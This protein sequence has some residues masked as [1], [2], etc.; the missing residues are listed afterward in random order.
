MIV[1]Q[2]IVRNRTQSTVSFVD[3]VHLL[4]AGLQQ[5]QTAQHSDELPES[6]N[7]SSYQ[8]RR[9]PIDPDKNGPLQNASNRYMYVDSLKWQTMRRTTPGVMWIVSVNVGNSSAFN[10]S[11]YRIDRCIHRRFIKRSPQE[12]GCREFRC[13]VGIQGSSWWRQHG[14]KVESV[15]DGGHRMAQD[16][17]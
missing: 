5:R 14:A 8:R 13:P 10:E 17:I 11:C 9:E 15:N 7:G 3:V 4:V 12:S 2:D 16:R 6:A 1:L